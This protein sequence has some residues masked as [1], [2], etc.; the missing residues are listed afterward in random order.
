M[1]AMSPSLPLAERR[2]ARRRQR[3]GV[4]ALA[5]IEGWR[6][7]RHP[8]FLIGLAMSLFY[9]RGAGDGATWQT[10]LDGW[11]FLPVAGGT[12]IAANLAALRSR[13][14]RTDELYSSLP[15]PR[16]WRTAGQLLGLAGTV[17]VCATLLAAAYIDNTSVA[18][19]NGVLF[20][21]GLV[22]LAQG[23]MLVIVLGAL[24]ILLARAAPSVIAGPLTIVAVFAAQVP[25]WNA[26]GSWLA[27]LLPLSQGVVV[28]SGTSI[29]CG[30][31]GTGPPCEFIGYASTG[32]T[33]HLSYV[34]GL[35]LLAGIAALIPGRRPL[36]FA[37]LAAL[38]VALA[39]GTKLA[40]G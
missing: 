33:W 25:G 14:D 5:R 16:S 26:H 29:R 11:A 20:T 36:P 24:G 7:L 3:A 22:E 6:L 21:P 40:A 35:A 1:S 8:V 10:F 30:P 31:G 13:R 9:F 12:L 28:Q 27:W 19:Q 17:A 23:P 38:A 32:L 37:G 34:I 39:I 4:L 15:G 18:N 2:T